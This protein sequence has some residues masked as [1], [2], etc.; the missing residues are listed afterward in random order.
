MI[1]ESLYRAKR[2]SPNATFVLILEYGSTSLAAKLFSF[3]FAVDN[4]T[5]LERAPDEGSHQYEGSKDT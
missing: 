5:T 4:V 1:P 2:L 3:F